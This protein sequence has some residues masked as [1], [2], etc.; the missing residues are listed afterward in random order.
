MLLLV[1]DF[2]AGIDPPKENDV[3]ASIRL[4]RAPPFES[5]PLATGQA[6]R[7]PLFYRSG[8]WRGK[9]DLTN[10]KLFIFSILVMFTAVSGG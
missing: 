10:Y 3:V 4:V 7:M 8:G 9:G 5:S 2:F 1:S 6:L